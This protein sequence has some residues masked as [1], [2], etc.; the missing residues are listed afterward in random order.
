MSVRLMTLSL[1]Y[2]LL[3]DSFSHDLFFIYLFFKNRGLN[4]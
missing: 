1:C 3:S 4:E 2:R